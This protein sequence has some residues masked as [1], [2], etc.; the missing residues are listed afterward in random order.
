[1]PPPPHHIPH[2]HPPPLIPMLHT[3]PI[4]RAHMWDPDRMHPARP[5]RSHPV[6]ITLSRGSHTMR[7]RCAVPVLTLHPTH[8]HPSA[9]SYSNPYIHPNVF[10]NLGTGAL[11]LGTNITCDGKH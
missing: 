10:D 2:P 6:L 9:P 8:P 7:V 5:S 4:S 3:S 1:M 11:C